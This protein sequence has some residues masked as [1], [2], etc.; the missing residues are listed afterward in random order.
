M[1][2]GNRRSGDQLVN[3]GVRD[4]FAAIGPPAVA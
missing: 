3:V 4:R 2:R 1:A